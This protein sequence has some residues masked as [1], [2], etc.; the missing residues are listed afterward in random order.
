MTPEETV[1]WKGSPSQLTH[2]RTYL[3]WLLVAA[4]IVGAGVYFQKPQLFS[5]LLICGIAMWIRWQVTKATAYELTTQRLRK[6]TGLFSKKLSELEL[7]HVKDS[8]LEQPLLL[9]IVGAGNIK[10][11]TSDALNPEMDLVAVGGAYSVRE[12][13]RAAVEVERDRKRVRV[14]DA[15]AE[16]SPDAGGH[17]G[18]A[19]DHGGGH[20]GGVDHAGGGGDA[21]HAAH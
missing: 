7:Y 4:L 19:V 13:L 12:K 6:T 9:R 20:D 16:V 14:L 21:G 17:D 5:A 3:L 1:L 8:T 18:G 15:D 11:I 10:V 2:V